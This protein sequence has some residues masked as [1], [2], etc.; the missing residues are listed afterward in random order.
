VN[1]ALDT[2][3]RANDSYV[4]GDDIDLA[5]PG[6]DEDGARPMA[7]SACL[8]D[9]LPHAWKSDKLHQ[10]TPFYRVTLCNRGSCVPSRQNTVLLGLIHYKRSRRSYRR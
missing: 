1:P 4:L 7:D 8:L 10:A 2:S 9:S 3:S 6:V 5:L